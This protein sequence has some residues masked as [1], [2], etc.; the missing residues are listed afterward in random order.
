[1]KNPPKGV[2]DAQERQDNPMP[3]Y[4]GPEAVDKTA[5]RTALRKRQFVRVK[6]AGSDIYGAPYE[7]PDRSIGYNKVA[8]TKAARMKMADKPP[9][10]K[11]RKAYEED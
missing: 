2:V 7:L 8:P 9:K 3:E 4:A 1:M 5:P 6:P 10:I 11:P